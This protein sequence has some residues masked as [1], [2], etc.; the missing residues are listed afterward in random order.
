MPGN[1]Q[2]NTLI[3]RSLIPTPAKAATTSSDRNSV[4]QN[5]FLALISR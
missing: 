2:T 1:S 5:I 3:P 4:I